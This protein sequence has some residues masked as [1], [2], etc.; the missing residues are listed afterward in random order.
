MRHVVLALI[1]VALPL[2]GMAQQTTYESIT[3]DGMQ[4]EYI[5][6]VPA[7]Y[8]GDSSVP[9]ILNYHGYTSNADIHMNYADFRPIADTAGFIVV[10]PQGSLLDGLTHWNVG[11]WTVGSTVDD[12]GF[13]DH[14]IDS[15]AA[16]YNID[17]NRIYS[18]G[19][20]NGGYMSFLLACQL[21]DRIAAI[22]SVGGSMTPET[23][24][25][26]NPTHPM[27]ILQMHGTA[28]AI[29]PYDGASWT[30]PIETVLQ[31]W[32]A[33]DNCNPTPTVT[34][35]PDLDPTD[36]STVEHIVYGGGDNGVPVE[37][38]RVIDGPHQWPGAA[39]NMDI[40]ASS[41]I[42]EFFTRYDINGL[43]EAPC[44]L[45]R[46]D[47]DRSGGESPIDIS[48]LV[49]LVDYMFQS[50]PEPVCMDDANI[51]GSG[52]DL[53]DIGDLV[54]LVGFMFLGGPEPVPCP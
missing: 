42:W 13:T 11:G 49:Y 52:D 24:D 51:D 45:I 2:V 7:G 6:Y 5:L 53:I 20:S 23:Y 22:A 48:D 40:D 46:A 34:P 29:V 18:T 14:L 32:V 26:A 41:V 50:G 54:Y 1:V 8:T 21:G 28:D 3:H 30:K 44:C 31:Y 47:L 17:L 37:H 12:V 15:L 33:F 38:Y 10:H 16:E 9:L 27:P 43:V 19:M 4:R 35:L 39:G 36:G 25:E